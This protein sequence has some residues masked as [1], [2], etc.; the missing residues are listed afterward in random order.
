MNT[1][2]LAKHLEI[3]V[4]YGLSFFDSLIASATLS[5][6]GIVVSDGKDFDNVP[7]IKRIPIT[8]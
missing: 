5:I 2:A 8:H 3:M 1:L 4:N 6:D 7:E